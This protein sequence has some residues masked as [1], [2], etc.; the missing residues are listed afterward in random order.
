MAIE[1]SPS[2]PYNSYDQIRP[3]QDK[4]G[5][6]NRAENNAGAE[7]NA[8]TAP[9]NPLE[10]Q[11]NIFDK[12]QERKSSNDIPDDSI[13]ARYLIP[14]VVVIFVA[15]FIIVFFADN[16]FQ[17]NAGSTGNYFMSEGQALSLG[18]NINQ[19][20]ILNFTA[21]NGSLQKIVNSS[22]G[23][24]PFLN[25]NVTEGWFYLYDNP[26]IDEGV[27]GWVWKTAKPEYI[28]AQELKSATTGSSGVKF[29]VTNASLD[30]LTYSFE[31][32]HSSIQIQ[33]AISYSTVF[34][35]YNSGA[36][37]IVDVIA[38]TNLNIT[39]GEL[40]GLIINDT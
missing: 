13:I 11:Q 31:S 6:G 27:T 29:N 18:L 5:E 30:G 3:S 1:N 17:G 15:A 9:D 38:Q 28:Y 7:M 2:G 34:I 14:I 36:V 33:N 4:T 22:A 19:S 39:A 37:Y 23:T 8:R 10:Q 12:I 20:G 25:G 16:M 21:K 40:A 24:Q 35:G 32:A 26:K